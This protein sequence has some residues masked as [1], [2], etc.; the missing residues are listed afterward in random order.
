MTDTSNYFKIVN[1]EKKT[2]KIKQLSGA[3]LTKQTEFYKD[4]GFKL[5]CCDCKL[6]CTF[7]KLY[8]NNAHLLKLQCNRYICSPNQL[9][10]SLWFF[11]CL[12]PMLVLSTVH[13]DTFIKVSDF[14]SM[15]I[16]WGILQWCFKEFPL[17]KVFPKILFSY[18]IFVFVTTWTGHE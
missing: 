5:T 9:G 8:F 2:R 13:V 6:L 10:E 16:P 17:L 12:Q 11:F 4:T 15:S 7:W 18:C 3:N 1:F 14:V